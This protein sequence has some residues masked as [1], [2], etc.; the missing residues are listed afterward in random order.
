MLCL[1]VTEMTFLALG[2][3]QIYLN[4]PFFNFFII[5]HDFEVRGS[6]LKHSVTYVRRIVLIS[7]C[8]FMKNMWLM[9]EFHSLFSCLPK[10]LSLSHVAM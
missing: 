1:E 8:G 7:F 4:R 9:K 6:F 2:H 10:I 3:P 5:L